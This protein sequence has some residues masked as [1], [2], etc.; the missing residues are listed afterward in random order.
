MV[1]SAT[2]PEDMLEMTGRFMRNPLKILVKQEEVP[3]QAIRQYYVNVEREVC[4]M[5]EDFSKNAN[6]TG[7]LKNMVILD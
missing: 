6:K 4:K 7:N 3:L 1:L 2:M 5:S